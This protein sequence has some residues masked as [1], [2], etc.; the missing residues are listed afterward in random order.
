[1]LK[2]ISKLSELDIERLMKVYSEGNLENGKDLF[3]DENLAVQQRMAE[4]RFI[5]YL[6]EDFFQNPGA[7]YA[8]WISEGCYISALRLEPYRDGLL[9]EALETAPDQRRKGYATSLVNEVVDYLRKT[10]Y[11][12]VYS[13]ISKKNVPSLKVHEKCG[14][15]RV[16]DSAIY[17]DG[18]VT[19]NS[20]TLCYYLEKEAL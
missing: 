16:A 20:F 12:K 5:E 19:Q 15:Q 10:E 11:K 8:L 9:L 17:I 2:I 1:M 7:I 6:R 13:H 14:F 4:D 18:T 3:P